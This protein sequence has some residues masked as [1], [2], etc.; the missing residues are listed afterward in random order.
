MTF[1]D[2][3][4][5]LSD[6]NVYLKDLSKVFISIIQSNV[7]SVF[8]EFALGMDISAIFD[9]ELHGVAVAVFGGPV[10]SCH[11]QHVFGVDVSTML[12]NE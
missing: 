5:H 8:A 10:E 7:Q 12:L 4:T 9:E 11:F 1:S 2:V 6:S 3:L